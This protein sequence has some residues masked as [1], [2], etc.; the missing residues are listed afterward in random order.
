MSQR[1]FNQML[2][3]LGG[4]SPEQMAT[5]RR[6]LDK[7]AAARPVSGK[8]PAAGQTAFDVIEQAG[9]IGC[10]KGRPGSPADLATN[11]EHMEGFGRD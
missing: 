9:L 8:R 1:E 10:V 4:L 3:S 7:V 2:D 11:P 5:L 6:E